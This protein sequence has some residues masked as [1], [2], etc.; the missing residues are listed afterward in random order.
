MVYGYA[1]VSTQG[2]NL[3]RQIN[4]LRT[5]AP[6]AII[7]TEKFT[8]TTIDR[9]EWSKLQKKLKSGDVVYFDEVARM[10]RNAEEGFQLYKDL[11]DKG[12]QL[13]FVRQPMMDTEN[14]RCVQH[15]ATIGEEI[16]DVYIEAT[17]KVLMLLAERQIK[18]AFDSAEEEVTSKRRNTSQG[19]QNRIRKYKEEELLGLPHEKLMPGRQAGAVI[20]TKKSK[21]MK[22]KIR[23]M[24]KKF[25]GCMSDKEILETLGL[26]RNT[27]YK[28]LREMKGAEE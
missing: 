8:G 26:A 10:S 14:F 2:Q 22:E 9:P 4:T 23:K 28:Y 25:S 12:V 1:R 13:K 17:N 27:Y 5:V 3:E 6:D 19:V 11:Y 21:E 24:S 15:I 7:V 18:Q 20:E 16:A